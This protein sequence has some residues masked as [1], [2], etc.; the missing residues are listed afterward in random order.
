[1]VWPRRRQR[2]RRLA[3]ASALCALGAELVDV[4]VDA[5]GR[6]TYIF[7]GAAAR[8]AAA[9]LRIAQQRLLEDGAKSAAQGAVLPSSHS[10]TR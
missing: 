7:A 6:A 9:R 5:A 8:D 3:R 4:V 10:Q 1:M 2:T